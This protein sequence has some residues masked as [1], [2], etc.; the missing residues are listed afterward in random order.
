MILVL[1]PLP[2]E[3]EEL[4]K[5]LSPADDFRVLTGGHGKV[6]FAIKT[7]AFIR[8]FRPKRVVCAGAAGALKANVKPLDVVIATQTIEHDFNLK[9]IQ[10]PLPAFAGDALAIQS[11]QKSQYSFP[12]HFGPVA[13]GDEDVVDDV[14]AREIAIKTS[15]LA[16]AWEGAG[17]ARACLHERISFLEVRGITDFAGTNAISEFRKNLAPAMERVAQVIKQLA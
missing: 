1:T 11:L 17:G 4:R 3:C 10:R 15:A 5:N 8:E 14:R 9:F 2:L 7:M 13:S 6:E 12:V 16:V